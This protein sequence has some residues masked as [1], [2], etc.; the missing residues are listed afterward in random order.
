MYHIVILIFICVMILLEVAD[1]VTHYFNQCYYSVAY[2]TYVVDLI[3]ISYHVHFEKLPHFY[4][5]FSIVFGKKTIRSSCITYS[6][7]FCTILYLCGLQDTVK[8]ENIKEKVWHH[9]FYI[10][11]FNG[12]KSSLY[13]H[14]LLLPVLSFHS[15]STQCFRNNLE[16]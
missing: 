6:V 15:I 10:Y 1:T 14:S 3:R 12:I 5:K 11:L 16:R 2:L 8:L 7:I 9:H 13:G 4:D